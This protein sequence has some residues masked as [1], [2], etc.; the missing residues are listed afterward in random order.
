MINQKDQAGS[1]KCYESDHLI[2]IASNRAS[3]THLLP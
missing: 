3:C 2:N 1:N